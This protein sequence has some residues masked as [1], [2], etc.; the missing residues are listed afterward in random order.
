VAGLGTGAAAVFAACG[1]AQVVTVE[2]IV[3]KEVPVEKIVIKEVPVEKVVTQ[4]VT[5]E[6]PVEK[7]VTQVVTKEVPVEV[8][9]EVQVD[10]VRE[11]PAQGQVAKIEFA[12]DHV[13]G[14]RGK[15]MQW[16]IQ[17]FEALRPDIAVRMIPQDPSFYEKVAA[18]FVAGA[19]PDVGLL[20]GAFFQ[21]FVDIEGGW[22][23]ID[24]LLAK[25]PDYDADQIWFTPDEASDNRNQDFPYDATPRGPWYGLPYQGGV[26][27]L[28]HNIDLVDEMGAPEPKEGWRW[29]DLLEAAKQTTD[30]ENNR[31]GL[32]IDGVIPT[33]LAWGYNDSQYRRMGPDGH[34]VWT[35]YEG[36]GIKG[37]QW[38]ADLVHTH[39]VQFPSEIRAELSGDRGNPFQAGAQ[40]Y[41]VSSRLRSAGFA[42]PRI[43]GRFRWMIDPTPWGPVRDSVDGQSPGSQPHIV[44]QSAERTGVAEQAVAWVV[45]MAGPEVQGRTGI[46]RGFFPVNKLVSEQ[47][48]ALAPP[49]EGMHNLYRIPEVGRIRHWQNYVPG[50]FSGVSELG[51][52]W[53]PLKSRALL[54]EISAEEAVATA[55]PQYNGLLRKWQEALDSGTS[56]R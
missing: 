45:W 28:I 33:V 27:G 12:T 1:E 13:S 56:R 3:T 16:A 5:K 52:V 4:V 40:A 43:G 36:D 26:R 14:P 41:E 23:K 54:G 32:Y 42:N 2:K 17:R 25:N 11:V 53:N 10:V 29:D 46:D 34:L 31:W 8:I 38:A 22:L 37:L 48:D 44:A 21:T 35:E 39:G 9:K 24:D 19:L 15:A 50:A 7:V 18:Q 49:P 20:S 30:P 6:V 47:P 55:E 51:A